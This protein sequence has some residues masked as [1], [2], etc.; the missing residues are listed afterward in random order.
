MGVQTPSEEGN[1]HVVLGYGPVL[2]G[3]A[4]L[5]VSLV[6]WLTRSAKL[7]KARIEG[8]HVAAAGLMLIYFGLKRPGV[9]PT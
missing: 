8:K 7:V 2:L 4:F 6:E 3:G 1:M 9:D 5:V